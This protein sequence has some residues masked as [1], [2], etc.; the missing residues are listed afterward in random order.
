MDIQSN[1]NDKLSKLLFLPINKDA[2]IGE[3]TIP[4]DIYLPIKAEQII[5]KVKQGETFEKIPFFY[6]VEGMVYVLGADENFKYNDTYFELLSNI[7]ESI[8]YIKG[9]IYNAI[10][11]E[12]YEDAY[13]MLKGLTRIENDTDNFD[14]LLLVLDKLRTIDK[15]YEEEELKMIEKGKM[16]DK[17]ATP[18]LYKALVYRDKKDFTRALHSLN[19]YLSMG[20][21][22]TKEISEFKENLKN[23]NDYEKGVQLIYENPN[24]ALK[25]LIPLIDIYGDTAEI[26]YYIAI[27]YRNLGI[28]EKAIYYLN[29]ASAVD[30]ALIEVLNEYGINYAAM[31]DYKTAIEYLKK[32]FQ[33]SKSVEIC[34]NIV[35]CYIDMK[36]FDEAK[37]YLE[38]AEKIDPK[39]DIVVQLKNMLKDI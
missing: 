33:A 5:D 27:A 9:K 11:D 1:F 16:I 12:V 21:T 8:K 15:N 32:A 29:E 36:K 22:E 14:R 13:I 23:I 35:M 17:F 4:K 20:G 24:E 34:T 19:T 28:H 25:V 38:K 37:K 26:F 18:Y 39:D 2:Q 30:S 3:Y 6:F 7:E 31:G 10:N